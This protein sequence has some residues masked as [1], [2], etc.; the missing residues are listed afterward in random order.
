M[1]NRLMKNLSITIP[2]ILVVKLEAWADNH[3]SNRFLD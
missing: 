1:E 2:G 3:Q